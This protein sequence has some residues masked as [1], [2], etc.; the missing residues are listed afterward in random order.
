MGRILVDAG[1][2]TVLIRHPMPYGDLSAMRVQRFAS[3]SDI[4]AA[5]PSIE[6]R[7]EYEEPVRQGLVSSPVSTTRR[8]SP[9]RRQKP[10]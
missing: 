2:R 5:A 4:D 3:L 10:T 9:R 7:E 8:S 1:L 6:E